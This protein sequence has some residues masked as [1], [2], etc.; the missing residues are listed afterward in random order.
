MVL[1]RL[2]TLKALK[3][4][5]H[6]FARHV[7]TEDNGIADALSRQQWTRFNQ[8]TKD[9]RI[10]KLPDELPDEIWPITKLWVK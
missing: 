9:K 6:C 4:N 1:L 5:F 3:N 2:L 7:R 8:L 10:N